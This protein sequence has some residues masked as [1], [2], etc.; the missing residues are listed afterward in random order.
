LNKA[1]SA[2]FIAILCPIAVTQI[3]HHDVGIWQDGRR[4]KDPSNS[5]TAARTASI[6]DFVVIYSP[7]WNIT[8]LL[9]LDKIF[10]SNNT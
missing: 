8:R 3:V 7:S 1:E 4:K 9:M 10:N 2:D 6:Y 5:A